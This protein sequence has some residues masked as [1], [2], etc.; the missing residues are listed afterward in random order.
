MK[1]FYLA[2]VTEQI[3]VPLSKA[4]NPVRDSVSWQRHSTKPFFELDVFVVIIA[5]P[6]L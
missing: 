5:L 4:E 1:E 6:F 2:W 3:M